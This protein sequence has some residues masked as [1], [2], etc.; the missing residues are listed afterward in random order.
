MIDPADNS[1]G[2]VCMHFLNSKGHG[3]PVIDPAHQYQ[4][5]RAAHMRYPG[6]RNS[7]VFPGD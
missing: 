6:G 3:H 1:V 2:Q 4:V 5:Y 7:L